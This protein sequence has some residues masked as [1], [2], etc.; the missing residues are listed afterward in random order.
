MP[1]LSAG[2]Y[3][4]RRRDDYSTWIYMR[5]EAAEFECGH[6]VGTPRWRRLE[7]LVRRL[8]KPRWRNLGR[9]LMPPDG[10]LSAA[11]VLVMG[12]AAAI[13]FAGLVATAGE[14]AKA[15]ISVKADQV[16]R[17]MRGGLGASWHAIETPMLGS[18]EGGALGGSAWGANPSPEDEPAWQSLYRHANWLGLDWCRVEIEQRMYEPG[19]RRFEW[20][21]PEMRILYRILD[22]AEQNGV[23]VFLQQMWGNVEWNAYPELRKD[24]VG[25]ATSA[26]ASL[27]EFAHGLAELAHHL[28]RVKGYRSI[29]W[30]AIN[31]EPGY[32]WSWW[33]GPDGKPLPITPG[34][35]AV[36][37]ALDARGV[38][39]PLSGPDWTD[40]PELDP[41]KVDF[42]PWIGAYDLHSY[43]AVFDGVKGGYPLRVAEQRIARWA[44]WAHERNK[45]LFLSELGTMG[46]GWGGREAGPGSYQ[47]G[48]KDAALVV[49]GIVAGVDGFNRWSFV[50]R[51]DLDGQWQ[52]VDTWDADQQKLRTRFT[53]HPNTYY[54]YGLLS[55]FTAKNSDVLHTRVEGTFPDGGRKLV[56]T[57][58]RSPKGALTILVVN[59]APD[60]VDATIS[61]EGLGEETTL[62]R[63]SITEAESDRADVAVDS[64]RT[65]TV[66]ESRKT[67]ADHLAR[68]SV[69][70]YS[71]YKLGVDSP[72]IAVGR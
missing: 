53:P 61:L 36:R 37:K 18:R 29:R 15:R 25:I 35:E 66:G 65:F 60:A 5:E 70:V 1:A 4:T 52:L 3:G 23:D 51:G 12:I 42:D 38:T 45:P 59:E 32:S 64:Q 14:P 20:D 72:G 56:A 55:R 11:A 39:L 16:V 31:N 26:P 8:T 54:L 57:A 40:L 19:K 71:T 6:P 7:A 30:L 46:Y 69:S 67:I 41:Q 44:N 50:N 68:F 13:L 28:L 21:N 58:L 48:L 49:R 33:Q 27:D 63:Y 9:R 22:W 34:L 62:H 17:T 43:T 10:P 2:M 24:S 47:A